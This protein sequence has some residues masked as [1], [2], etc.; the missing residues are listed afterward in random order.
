MSSEVY[1]SL[2][3]PP[4]IIATIHGLP[5][6]PGY[7][8][9]EYTVNIT[10]TKNKSL[11]YQATILNNFENNTVIFKRSL[12]SSAV[13][14]CNTLRI[15]VSAMSTTHGDSESTQ[16]NL[17]L[18]K[19]KSSSVSGIVQVHVKYLIFLVTA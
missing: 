10:E 7:E 17:K 9:S 6:W 1:Y 2:S 4:I 12:N 5:R 19:G 15:S 14:E 8:I 13:Q 3:L 18:L 16:T 11:L